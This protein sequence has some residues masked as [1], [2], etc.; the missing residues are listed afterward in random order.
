M[1]YCVRQNG[2]DIEQGFHPHWR[3]GHDPAERGADADAL[4]TLGRCGYRVTHIMAIT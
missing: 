1:L 3:R 4:A 2:I